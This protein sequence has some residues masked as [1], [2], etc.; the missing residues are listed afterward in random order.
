MSL[1]FDS[2]RL[3]NIN[4]EPKNESLEDDFPFQ[5]G[6]FRFQPL[7]FQGVQQIDPRFQ[8]AFY[9]SVPRK[10]LET[11]ELTLTATWSW[12]LGVIFSGFTSIW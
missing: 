12:K 2:I 11:E 9:L 7:V 6:D 5:T 4:I 8:T 3:P 10:S 1:F